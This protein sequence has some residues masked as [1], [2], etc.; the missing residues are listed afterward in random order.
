M[1]KIIVY[2]TVSEGLETFY[3]DEGEAMPYVTNNTLK[4][5]EFRGSSKS[6]VL[7][8]TKQ[9]MEAWNATRS[10]YGA[11]IPVGYAFK[12]IWEGGHGT[13]SQHYAGVSFDVGQ[14][15]SAAQRNKI[16]SVATSLGVW[17]YVEPQYMTPTWVHFDRRYGTPAC[18]SGSSG[19]TSLKQCSRGVYV[20]IMQDA[21]NTLGYS[22]A[23]L[24]GKFG[25][26]SRIAVA[27]FQ[28]DYGLTP[29]GVCG[30]ATWTKLAGLVVGKGRTSTTVD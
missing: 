14:T 16:H 9:A 21:L 1:A 3:K 18:G 24:D 23:G 8:T 11:P 30:C 13:M 17:G 6:E 29:D 7:W 27:H 19:Y 20:L 22:T 10:A 2:D 15:L 25:N 5:R 26:A 12:R 4:V 28:G